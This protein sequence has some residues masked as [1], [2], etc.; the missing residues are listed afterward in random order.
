MGSRL[1][2]TQATSG[3]PEAILAAANDLEE[4]NMPRMSP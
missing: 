4:D 2:T 3:D 1:S